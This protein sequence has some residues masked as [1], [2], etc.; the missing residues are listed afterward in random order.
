MKDG[1]IMSWRL[2]GQE[3]YLGNKQLIK[4]DIYSFKNKMQKKDAF[5]EHCEFCMDK[6]ENLE[7][8]YTTKNF[9][10]WICPKCFNDFKESF[11]MKEHS[12]KYFILNNQRK[13]TAY[14]VFV[15][16]KPKDQYWN[17]YSLYI[18]DDIM[19]EIQLYKIFED[20]KEDYGY[21]GD[22]IIDSNKWEQIIRNLNNYSTEI[23][24]AITEIFEWVNF[25]FERYK[26]FTIL[27]I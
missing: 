12:Y 10:R 23:Q 20:N 3:K 24:F 8:A 14:H 25:A 15:F 18:S 19:Q 5:H 16:G 26:C 27:G 9:Y 11:S 7:E 2:Q 4:V 17:K 22:T 13:G 6:I 21:F 1:N